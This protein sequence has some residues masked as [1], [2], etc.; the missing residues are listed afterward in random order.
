VRGNVR[1]N[2]LLLAGAALSAVAG[3]LHFACI[4]LGAPAFRWLGAGERLARRAERG[5]VQPRLIAFA[6]G[7][8]LC[9]C[10][11][12]ALS[13][14]GVL[15]PWPPAAPLLAVYAAVLGLRA[16]AFPL[17]RPVFP[18]NSMAFWWLSSALCL[19]MALLHALGL[20]QIWARP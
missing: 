1:A 16:L 4:V 12:L 7:A 20:A 18:E 3:L 8:A 6:I 2:P 9:L 11:G 10:A 15:P 13:V 5:D 17:L 19:G 14:A